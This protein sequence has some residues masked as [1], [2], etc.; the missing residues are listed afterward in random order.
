MVLFRASLFFFFAF[1]RIGGLLGPARTAVKAARRRVRNAEAS[2][3]LRNQQAESP[4]ER[5]QRGR[6]HRTSEGAAGRTVTSREIAAS[7]SG[8]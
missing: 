6:W 1:A 3:H 5:I 4:S 2:I 8:M 7:C